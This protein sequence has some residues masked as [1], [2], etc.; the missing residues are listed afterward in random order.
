MITN[1]FLDLYSCSIEHQPPVGHHRDFRIAQVLDGM[2]H[3]GERFPFFA[4][5][6]NN[7]PQRTIGQNVPAPFAKNAIPTVVMKEQIRKCVVWSL[8]PNAIRFE[9]PGLR[10]TLMIL[11][12]ENKRQ[13]DKENGDQ[14]EMVS[15]HEKLWMPITAGKLLFRLC[16]LTAGGSQDWKGRSKPGDTGLPPQP[17]RLG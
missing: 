7:H 16:R 13:M 10:I 5:I 2:R 12:D 3:Q 1:L 8:V 15:F 9:Q 17:R 4:V 11:C 14:P 6:R